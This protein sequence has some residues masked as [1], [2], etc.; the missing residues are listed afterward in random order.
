M[1]FLEYYSPLAPNSLKVWTV[2]LCQSATVWSTGLPPRI[3]PNMSVQKF[4]LSSAL[5]WGLG[6]AGCEVPW[7]ALGSLK[8]S[9]Q[10][11]VM[12]LAYLDSVNSGSV[13]PH[14]RAGYT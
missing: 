6:E 10:T 14:S 13:Q 1:R 9:C 11:G 7:K 8:I 4:V 12:F 5:D 3:S 2:R